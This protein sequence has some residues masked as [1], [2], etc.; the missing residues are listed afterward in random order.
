M[1]L[2]DTA[3]RAPGEKGV[4]R[5]PCRHTPPAAGRRPPRRPWAAARHWR[6]S[7]RHKCPPPCTQAGTRSSLGQGSLRYPKQSPPPSC[8]C[9]PGP[10]PAFAAGASPAH[11]ARGPPPKQPCPPEAHGR[12]G[13]GPGRGCGVQPAQD[14][15]APAHLAAAGGGGGGGRRGRGVPHA[16]AVAAARVAAPLLPL[17]PQLGGVAAHAGARRA[18]AGAARRRRVRGL[19]LRPAARRLCGRRAA[20][21]VVC[22]LLRLLRGLLGGH[23]GGG[24]CDRGGSAR[25]RQRCIG[26]HWVWKHARHLLGALHLTAPH[27][28]RA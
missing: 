20:E 7:P 8:P 26:A 21:G 27:C 16:P 19:R 4:L 25:R 18:G 24:A 11:Q 17:L 22:A 5:S 13:P 23:G 14:A 10:V 9:Q 3:R 1:P 2:K 15:A 6:R 28:T 12:V